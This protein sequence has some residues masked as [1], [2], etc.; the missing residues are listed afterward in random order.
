[1]SEYIYFLLL[2]LL[3]KIISFNCVWLVG[4]SIVKLSSITKPAYPFF[5]DIFTLK[6]L[7]RSSKGS[8]QYLK[9]SKTC[10]DVLDDSFD[11]LNHADEDL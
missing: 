1:M 7:K 11:S 4:K 3:E 6:T 5:E 8:D 9:T 2:T 10:T